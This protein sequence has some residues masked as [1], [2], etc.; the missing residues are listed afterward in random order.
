M[1]LCRLDNVSITQA[2]ILTS[3]FMSSDLGLPW[4]DKQYVEVSECANIGYPVRTFVSA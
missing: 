1:L 2:F 3:Q 4:R